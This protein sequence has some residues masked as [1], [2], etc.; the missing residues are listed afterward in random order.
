MK[1]THRNQKTMNQ[2]M[3]SALIA[4][5]F[6]LGTMNASANMPNAITS[7]DKSMQRISVEMCSDKQPQIIAMTGTMALSGDS[8][9]ALAFFTEKAETEKSLEMEAW[10]VDNSIFSGEENDRETDRRLALENWMTDTKIW[11]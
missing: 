8:G 6:V 4:I 10:M 9:A 5:A 1:T 3:A 7:S 2:K 11:K